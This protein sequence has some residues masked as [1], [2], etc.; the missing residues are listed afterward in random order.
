MIDSH[1]KKNHSTYLDYIKN[2]DQFVVSFLQ[3]IHFRIQSFFKSCVSAKGID[4]IR[5]DFINFNDLLSSIELHNYQV[6]IPQWYKIE[7]A[8]KKTPEGSGLKRGRDLDDTLPNKSQP[9][10]NDNL[11]A[12]CRINKDKGEV[13]RFVF[14]KK[15]LSGITLPKFNGVDACLKYH[16]EGRCKTTCARSGSHGKLTNSEVIELRKVCKQVRKN[17]LAFREAKNK[18]NNNVPNGGGSLKIKVK[19]M[20]NNC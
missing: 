12:A 5:F 14:H 3:V 11:D 9:V 18:T 17:Y 13:Y 20:K 8:K 16:V 15:N 6:V 7:L 19:K 2:E 1:V 10:S 4:K